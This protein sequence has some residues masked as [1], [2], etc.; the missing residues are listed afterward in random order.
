MH[1][2][3]VISIQPAAKSMIWP[4]IRQ[5]C[6]QPSCDWLKDEQNFLV[7]SITTFWTWICYLNL[8]FALTFAKYSSLKQSSG[9]K[10]KFNKYLT[11]N[12]SSFDST[13]HKTALQLKDEKHFLVKQTFWHWICYLNF[14]LKLQ[15]DISNS[16]N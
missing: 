14:T 11:E 1:K 4:I 13:N 12:F 7:R 15:Q 8:S 10:S 5:L 16:I 3:K 2:I 9:K 6:S